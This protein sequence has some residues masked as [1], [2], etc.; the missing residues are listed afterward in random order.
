MTYLVQK[1]TKQRSGIQRLVLSF[2]AGALIALVGLG[3][4]SSAAP[5]PGGGSPTSSGS[6]AVCEAIGSGADCNANPQGSADVNGIIE[7]VINVL[8]TIVGVTAVIMII[9]SGFKYVTSGGDSQKLTNA[10]NTII[11]S[12]IGL[13]IVAL[14]QVFV[15]YVLAQATKP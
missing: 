6:S 7:T 14:A 2:C 15:R 3:S 5:V 4:V 13:L 10:K 8:T 1:I 9:V 12:L 11:Y